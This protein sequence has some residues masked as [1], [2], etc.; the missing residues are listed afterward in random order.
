MGEI[1]TFTAEHVPDVANLYWRE[2][3]GLPGAA[4]EKLRSYFCRVLL[5]NPWVSPELPSLVYFDGARLVGF[6]GVIPRTMEFQGLPIRVAVTSQFVVDRKQH[7]GTAALELMRCFLRGPQDLAY[8]D[9]VAEEA[10]II[11]RAAGAQAARLYSF[12]WFRA[13]RPMKAVRE[14][15]GRTGGAL[16]LL[17][18]TTLTA[19]SPID[20]LLARL[21][22]PFRAPAAAHVSTPV[23]APKLLET[24]QVIGWRE[25][26]RPA[27]DTD[28][29]PWLIAQAAAARSRGDL[30]LMVVRSPDGALCGWYVYYAKRDGAST[31]LEIGV[32]RRDQFDAVFAALLRDAWDQGSPAV[33]GQSMPQFLVHLTRRFCI[34]RQPMTSVVFHA[35]KPGLADAILR[36]EAALSALDGE[37]WADFGAQC[38]G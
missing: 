18:R 29:F 19:G 2:M 28:S 33:K 15:A 20:A 10:F 23:D 31:V 5:Q 14:F 7:R 32:R 17:A 1:R 11:W 24:I 12:H 22:G 36:G 34:F 26:L 27:Y 6:L 35:S 21:P 30:R 8:C 4:G 9:G 37:R 3:R 13:L 16:G 25:P 38:N